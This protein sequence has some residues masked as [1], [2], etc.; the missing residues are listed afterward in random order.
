MKVEGIRAAALVSGKPFWEAPVSFGS[1]ETHVAHLLYMCFHVFW[2]IWSKK[3]TDVPDYFN[4]H[5]VAT[6]KT[7]L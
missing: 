5:V 3:V 7:W 2:Q 6:Y 4:L 1:D